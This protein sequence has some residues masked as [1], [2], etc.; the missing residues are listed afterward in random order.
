M[1]K[2]LKPL[3]QREIEVLKLVARGSTNQEI[4]VQLHISVNTVKA[5]LKNIYQKL[6]VN[7]RTEASLE[8]LGKGLLTLEAIP[9]QVVSALATATSQEE[10]ARTR[11]AVHPGEE[12]FAR[13][14]GLALLA[15]FTLI[16]ALLLATRSLGRYGRWET[17]L[18]STPLPPLTALPERQELPRWRARAGLPTPRERLAVVAMDG[19]IY[20]IGGRSMEG[21]SGALEVYDPTMDSWVLR[22]SKPTPVSDIRAAILGGKIYVPGGNLASGEASTALEVYDPR[23]DLW[24][25]RAP[26][27]KPVSGYALATIEGKLYLFGG[28]DGSERLGHPTGS[29]TSWGP[30]RLASVYV[31]DP[32]SDTW[33]SGTPMS[34]PRSDAGCAEVEGRAYIVGGYDGQSAL[35]L[36]ERYDPSR[37]GTGNP[38][39]EM[40]PL[41][42]PRLGPGVTALGGS[43]YVI[44][45]Q[46][47]GQ[48]SLAERYDVHQNAWFSFEAPLRGPWQHL[49][50]AGI[51][52]KLYALGGYQSGILGINE[53]YQALYRIFLPAS[54]G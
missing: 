20:A 38:W 34:T 9:S 5:H 4:A 18:P 11:P 10:L 22:S 26:L 24:E 15:A 37:E 42:L 17:Q 27:P 43:I 29:E 49:G 8:A 36:V 2:E 48:A 6:E 28:W 25:S 41:S 7:S 13:N 45:G 16:L 19:R 53:E 30:G 1:V 47:E 21:V 12:V 44:G 35:T 33:E 51:D 39:S 52:T 31:Y 46:G 54:P 23:E 40:P 14:R 3:S 32:A 50:L